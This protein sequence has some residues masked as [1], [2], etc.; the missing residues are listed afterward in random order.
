GSAGHDD[1]QPRPDAPRGDW[2]RRDK[3][4]IGQSKLGH[5]YAARCPIYG[6]RVGGLG[7]GTGTG[8]QLFFFFP[9]YG[10]NKSLLQ[11]GGQTMCSSPCPSSRTTSAR[12]AA[13]PLPLLR[14]WPAEQRCV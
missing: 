9:S 5:L 1:F 6:G 13:S 14:Q 11:W 4:L 12:R 10:G 8:R 3:H 7:R 2:C